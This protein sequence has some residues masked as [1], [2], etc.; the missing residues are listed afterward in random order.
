MI[1]SLCRKPDPLVVPYARKY[2]L[3]VVTRSI[4][5][6]FRQTKKAEDDRPDADLLPVFGIVWLASLVRVAG[7]VVQHETFGTEPTLALF[8]V[9]VLPCSLLAHLV[10]PPRGS[11]RTR[12]TKV[13]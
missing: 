2:K 8:C 12:R 4:D 9:L 7:A 10:S 13:D 5:R 1:K 11:F 6:W 3:G